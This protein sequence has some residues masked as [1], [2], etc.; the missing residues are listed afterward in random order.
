MATVNNMDSFEGIF[1]KIEIQAEFVLHS[2]VLYCIIL[3]CI[4]W[5]C[6]V[7]YCIV[8]YCKHLYSASYSPHQSE[9]LPVRDT[10]REERRVF[11]EHQALNAQIRS[12]KLKPH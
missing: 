11:G 9:A 2:I 3:Y 1:C 5:N 7:L 10:Q 8:L 12:G 6:I 4:V